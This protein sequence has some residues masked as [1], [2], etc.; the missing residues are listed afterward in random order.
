[1]VASRRSSILGPDGRPLEIALLS[2]EMAQPT[3]WG[4]RSVL[5]EGVA[6]GLTPERL[7]QIM[8]EANYGS[9][10]AYL[11][12]AIEMEERYLHYRSQL[13]TRRLAFEA[14]DLS[15][16]A[17]DGYPSKIL[18]AVQE[19]V[20]DPI[21]R[22]MT[23]D[24]QD[25]VAKGY[26]VVEPLWEYQRGQLRPVVYKHRD[27]RFFQFDLVTLEEL[28]LADMSNNWEGLPI[29]DGKFIRHTPRIATGVPLRRGLARPAAWAFMV[30]SFT[31]QDW[32]AFAEIYG[33]PLRVG[34]YGPQA[35][36][37]DKRM[38]LYALRSI[39]NDGAA[40]IPASMEFELIEAKGQHG[41]AV[42]GKLIDYMDRNVSKAVLGQTMTS[43]VGSS[44]GALAT[45]K[46]HN[47]VRLDIVRADGRQTAATVNHDL[48]RW[49]VAFNFGPQD[50]YPAVSFPVAEPEDTKALSDAV[51]V[52]VP[53]G[54]KVGQRE[55]RGRLGLSEPSAGED[56][57]A[58]ATPAPIDPA[59]KPPSP[60]PTDALLAAQLRTH[61]G[62]CSCAACTGAATLGAKDPTLPGDADA[63]DAL[64]AEELAEWQE[65]TDPLLE[66]IFALASE[67][68]SFEGVL[69][70]LDGLRLDS[71]PLVERL[72][73]A[74]AISRGIGDTER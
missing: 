33:I 1:M 47:E 52:L 61:A 13:Q 10:R 7:G 23:T 28:R 22:D 29:P 55:M 72:A 11:T 59:L 19:L 49:Y 42:F 24:L 14:I 53:L 68:T 73:R 16:T 31:L 67:E 6:S 46:V 64:M 15:V 32:S 57:L 54:L 8:R 36:E 51:A 5:M 43:D 9:A 26:A 25:G 38:L 45:A 60:K 17:P 37:Q 56:L 66:E 70:R 30:Q 21:F 27:P 65:V 39:A 20:H 74:T 58:P 40:A 3:R 50:T 2:E 41:E 69:R 48:I 4:P 63:I 62:A 71:R 12:L 18:D 35:T 44:G 34:K